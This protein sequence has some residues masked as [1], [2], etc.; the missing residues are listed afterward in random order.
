M[1]SQ[2][3]LITEAY[4]ELKR[5]DEYDYQRVVFENPYGGR[6][7]AIGYT[8]EADIAGEPLLKVVAEDEAVTIPF[9]RVVYAETMEDNK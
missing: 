6:D 8:V 1:T 4:R 7:T 5:S 9:A 2:Q 3:D